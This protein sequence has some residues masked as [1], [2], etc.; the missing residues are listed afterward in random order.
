MK[1][2]RHL[3][4]L[5]VVLLLC[6]SF[7]SGCTRPSG[8][9]PNL[10]MFGFVGID[11]FY[12]DPLDNETK[13]NYVDEVA[14][15][16]NIAHLCVFDYDDHIENR[17][18]FMNN[19]SIKPI[20]AIRTIFVDEV[21]GRYI[22]RDDFEQRW[23]HFISINNLSDET[24]AAFY[25]PD[26]PFHNN[27]PYED[28]NRIAQSIQTS[29]PN[30]PILLVEAYTALNNLIVPDV[31]D[32]VGFDQYDVIDPNTDVSYNL[33]FQK[34]LAKASG[35]DVFLIMDTQWR[36]YYQQE[37]NISPSD[38]ES[39]V[40]KYHNFSKNYE[41]IIGVIGYLWPGGLDEP[42]QLGARNLPENVKQV[43]TEIGQEIVGST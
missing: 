22:L 26:E 10:S 19:V 42:E 41:Q 40:L 21:E 31:V 20:V 13:T 30:I 6:V 2:K 36:P 34:L 9:N 17:V 16:T 14:G 32:W 33:N 7:F 18:L 4:F 8:S 12:D 24:I 39:I 43:L 29:H 15:F 35:K 11:C 27:L 5:L 1:N 23:S 3:C 28:L 25:L 38:M 37:G